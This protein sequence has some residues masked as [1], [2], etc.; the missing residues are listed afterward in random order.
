MSLDPYW[1]GRVP[2]VQKLGD[3][4]EDTVAHA[5]AALV[6]GL[7]FT[8]C[9]SPPP[10]PVLLLGHGGAGH[11]LEPF[12][13]DLARRFCTGLGAAVVVID[14][15]AHGDR[16]PPGDT[17]EDRNA[18]RL[19]EQRRIF[20]DPQA[21]EA[22]V[23]EWREALAAARG[24]DGVSG[25][26]GYAGFSMGTVLGVPAVAA[27]TEIACAVFAIGRALTPVDAIGDRDVLMLNMTRD[28]LIPLQASLE[29]FAALRGPKRIALW[30]GGHIDLPNEAI[31]LSIA[32]LRDRLR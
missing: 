3:T 29:M 21:I 12:T 30:E 20:R 13:Q 28:E 22:F 8:P 10:W 26:A 32:F 24:I 9:D 6:P 23:R 16:E 5:L 25:R 7:V 15:P 27:I 14:G 1:K 4:A 2:P 31:D 11:K 18:R 17:P 19:A